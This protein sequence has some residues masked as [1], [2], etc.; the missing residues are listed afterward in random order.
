MPIEVWTSPNGHFKI[1]TYIPEE[2]TKTR[3]GRNGPNA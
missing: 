2:D 3:P 1:E